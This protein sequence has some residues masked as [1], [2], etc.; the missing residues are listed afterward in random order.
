[1]S[2]NTENIMN[3]RNLFYKIRMKLLGLGVKADGKLE[4]TR[5]AKDNKEAIAQI[6]AIDKYY[7]NLLKKYTENK[8]GMEKPYKRNN[9]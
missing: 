6:D 7:D 9:K 3:L 4:I 8:D 2:I 1:M 5:I